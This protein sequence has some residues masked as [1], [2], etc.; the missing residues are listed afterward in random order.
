M[1]NSNYHF[2][3]L[4][5]EYVINSNLMTL[6]VIIIYPCQYRNDKSSTNLISW[7]KLTYLP[8]HD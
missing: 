4:E 2:Y 1:R 6:E 8:H 7:F 5:I 3:Q